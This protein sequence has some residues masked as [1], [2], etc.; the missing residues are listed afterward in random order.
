MLIFGEDMLDTVRTHIEEI[1]KQ[2][3]WPDSAYTVERPR[4]RS[5]GHV[6]TNIALT[7]AKSLKRKPVQIADEL[8][9]QLQSRIPGLKD[10]GIAGPGFINFTFSPD[11]FQDL[12]PRIREQKRDFRREN[13]EKGKKVQVEFVSANPTGPLTIGHGRQAVL[14]DSIARI[15]E[16]HGYEVTREYYFNDAGRQMRMLGL[17]V[18][19]RYLQAMG[20][21]AEIP[22]SGY[23]GEYIQ[24]IA[25]DFR[26]KYGDTKT[27]EH[28]QLFIDFA[29][30]EIFQ[31][32]RDSLKRLDIE[33][34]VYTNEKELYSSGKIDEV[35][36]ILEEK[37]YTY[38]ENGAIWFRAAQFGAEKDRVLVKNTGEPTYRLP[39][40]AYHR[41]KI[42][43]GFDLIIDIF[44]A[45]HHATYP[46]VKAALQALGYDTSNIKVLL[47]QFVTLT[48]EGE[49]VKMSTRKANFVTLDE[50]ID[51]TGADVVRYFY[52][53]RS[54]DS[55]LNFDIALAQK[56]SDEN[57]VFYL[58]YAHAR[59]CNI[60]LHSREKNI[61]SYES[62]D[63]SLLKEDEALALLE[64]MTEFGDIMEL[65]LKSLEPMHMCNYLYRLATAFHKFYT[66]HRVV[67]DNIALSKAR[68]Q[69][70]DAVRIVLANGLNILGINAPEKM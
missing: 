1:R 59:M 26:K 7:L 34:D 61:D 42:L 20:H 44:G 29:S 60:L 37:G 15:L 35:L 56:Q 51:L 53:M 13:R 4:D 36:K 38:Q 52:L 22:E 45:D 47:H 16:W 6:S 30:N 27:Q 39:D 64:I 28:L 68:L 40:I 23:E 54:M 69:L 8:A 33:H 14:G 12:I 21:K 17:S 67:T 55:H 10:V 65:C 49:K 19:A 50:L 24:D 63:L 43:R 11:Y 62:A 9:E 25:A 3:G 48:R 58:Q 46:D 5:F 2:L 31:L 41:E 32:I 57:P 66:V 18:M 70:V